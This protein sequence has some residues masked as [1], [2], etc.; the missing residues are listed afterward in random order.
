MLVVDD[1]F[2][3]AEVLETLLTEEGYRVMTASNGRQALARLAEMRP[4]AVLLDYMMPL[5]DGVGVL[6][7]IQAN[8]ALAGLPV[9]VMSS[10]PE[11]A[12]QERFTGHAAFLRKP[13]RI[14]EVLATLTRVLS[15]ERRR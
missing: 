3:V 15:Q 4:D 7:A 2:G 11:S 12:V 5:L 1:E 9:V 6:R 14:S 8:S 13:F 10:L